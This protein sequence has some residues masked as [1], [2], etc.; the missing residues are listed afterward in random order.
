MRALLPPHDDNN[1]RRRAAAT[2]VLLIVK[3]TPPPPPPPR[4]PAIPANVPG[5]RRDERDLRTALSPSSELSASPSLSLPPPSSPTRNKDNDWKNANPQYTYAQYSSQTFDTV[6]YFIFFEFSD[7]SISILPPF[8]R[9][10][11]L[12][13][14]RAAGEFFMKTV[15]F[16]SAVAHNRR[17]ILAVFHLLLPPQSLRGAVVV[18][19]SDRHNRGNR[20]TS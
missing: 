1:G 9:R 3:R 18:S 17:T 2:V 5:R 12:T 4:T 20:N 19:E 15:V 16:P 13:S 14:P 6:F 10:R 7:P 11:R 8:A